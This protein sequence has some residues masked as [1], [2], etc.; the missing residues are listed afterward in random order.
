MKEHIDRLKVLRQIEW[1]ALIKQKNYNQPL[2]TLDEVVGAILDVPTADVVEV[3]HGYWIKE[4]LCMC[5]P[6]YSCS[7]CGKLHDQDYSY[8]NDCG[9]KMDGERK[10]K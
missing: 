5:E 9:A 4:K 7:E 10:E 3:K 6:T 1:Y 8:C 2:L